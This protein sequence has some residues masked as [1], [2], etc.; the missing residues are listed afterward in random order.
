LPER[1]MGNYLISTLGFSQSAP[2]RDL[3]SIGI[4]LQK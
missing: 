2:V 1:N 3:P 4:P